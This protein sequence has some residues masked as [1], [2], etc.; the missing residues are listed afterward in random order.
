[1]EAETL[2]RNELP[3]SAITILKNTKPREMDRD[4][5]ACYIYLLAQASFKLNRPCISDS[6]LYESAVHFKNKG[7]ID[8][9]CLA[10]LYSG[11]I[12]FSEHDLEGAAI[13]MKQAEHLLPDITDKY[14]HNKVYSALTALNYAVANDSLALMYA[15]KELAAAVSQHDYVQLSFAYNH[16]GCIY[17]RLGITDSLLHYIKAVEPLIDSMPSYA[18]AQNLSNLGVYYRMLGDSAKGEL[19]ITHSYNTEPITANSNLLARIYFNRGDTAAAMNIWRKALAK[20]N[21]EEEIELRNSI[22][23]TLYAAG[24]YKE[25]GD[26]ASIA[27]LLK[28]SLQ[29]EQKTMKINVLQLDYDYRQSIK[30]QEKNSLLIVTVLICV[31]LIATI[32]ITVIIKKSRHTVAIKEK[33]KNRM[34]DLEAN[35]GRL[36]KEM[37]RLKKEIDNIEQTKILQVSRGKELF[38][39]IRKQGNTLRWSKNDFESFFSYYDIVDRDFSKRTNDKYS[40]LSQGNRLLLILTEMGFDNDSICRIMGIS[41]SSLRSSRCR[42]RG[43]QRK[44]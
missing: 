35:S 39:D 14:L 38:D 23:S 19:L 29:R 28:D 30:K 8:R 22:A 4:D 36:K 32:A 31:I 33:Y 34:V 12:R 37:L 43:K 3:D 16:L 10:T 18:R 1:M 11:M 13:R 2:L 7:D 15:R 20:A 9:E 27:T 44:S 6:L 41:A 24:K 26:N 17:A 40:S 25:S 42:L 21:A 5:Y